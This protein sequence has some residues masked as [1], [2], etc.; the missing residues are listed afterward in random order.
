[1]QVVGMQV[2][3]E[4][5]G[6]TGF[7]VEFV[8]DDGSVASVLVKNDREQSVNRLNAV[9]KAQKLMGELANRPMNGGT[10]NSERLAPGD[11][12]KAQRSAR[13]GN[14]HDELEE[15][16]DQGLEDTFPASDPV[17]ISQSTIATKTDSPR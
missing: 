14:N 17:S 1:M 16:L 5:M 4:Q 2:V 6:K 12:L 8:C 9:E 15:Q 11:S 13:Y 7:T 3:P 10:V